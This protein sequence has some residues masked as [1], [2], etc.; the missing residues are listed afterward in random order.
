MHQETDMKLDTQYPNPAK[1]VHCI[2]Y[3]LRATTNL[4]NMQPNVQSMVK[5]LKSKNTEGNLR[6][7]LTNVY[8]FQLCLRQCFLY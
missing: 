3:V 7:F 5:Y 8:N 2:L 6:F 4:D 1:V